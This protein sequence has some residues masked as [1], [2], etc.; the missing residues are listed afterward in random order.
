MRRQLSH[1]ESYLGVLGARLE[2]CPPTA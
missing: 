1:M 2:R